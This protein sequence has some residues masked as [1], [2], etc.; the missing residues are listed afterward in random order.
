[1]RNVTD[2]SCKEI[3][4]TNYVKWHFSEKRTVYDI[5]WQ[6]VESDLR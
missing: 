4:N 3:R 1:M 6:N 2:K 5:M